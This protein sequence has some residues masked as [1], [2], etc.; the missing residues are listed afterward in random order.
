LAKVRT[1]EAPTGQPSS[2]KAASGEAPS[3]NVEDVLG[4]SFLDQLEEEERKRRLA[5][6]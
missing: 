4:E 3:A 6:P 1:G 5:R 2:G